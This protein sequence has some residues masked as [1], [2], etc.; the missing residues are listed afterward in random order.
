MPT[1]N[2]SAAQKQGE[3]EFDR[4]L[5]VKQYLVKRL[6]TV[7]ANLNRTWK[8]DAINPPGIVVVVAVGVVWELFRAWFVVVFCCIFVSLS[9]CI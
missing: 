7:L 2:R 9:F 8:S 3:P 6:T 4:F 1:P 5:E